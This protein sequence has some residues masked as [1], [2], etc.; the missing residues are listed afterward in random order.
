M[1]KKEKDKKKPVVVVADED[2]GYSD[3]EEDDKTPSQG[4]FQIEIIGARRLAARHKR[5][6]SSFPYCKMIWG[7]EDDDQYVTN[8]IEEELN[9]RWKQKFEIDLR[10]PNLE[11]EEMKFEIWCAKT[12]TLLGEVT[13]PVAGHRDTPLKFAKEH[14]Y[15]LGG[16]KAEPKRQEIVTNQ[17]KK[18]KLDEKAAKGLKFKGDICLKFGCQILEEDEKKQVFAVTASK[19]IQIEDYGS[20][21]IEEMKAESELLAAESNEAAKRALRVAEQ[22]KA[23][24]ADTL[25]KLDS[26]GQKLYNA[27]SDLNQINA[28]LK[29][30]NREL[31]GIHSRTGAMKNSMTKSKW[32]HVDRKNMSAEQRLEFARQKEEERKNKGKKGKK[33]KEEKLTIDEILAQKKAEEDELRK[34]DTMQHLIEN[35]DFDHLSSDTQ[36]NMRETEQTLDAIQGAVKDLHGMAEQMSVTLD[37]QNRLIDELSTTTTQTNAR[38]KKTRM[39]V[40]REFD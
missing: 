7:E 37:E 3:E 9:P 31:R 16:G 20:V 12:K 36:Y 22:T 13:I 18:K 34:K 27:E 32:D 40:R 28:D 15:P 25:G 19:A 17:K 14:W 38:M 30:A 26:Q 8:T 5:T 10:G 39:K 29:E 6:E 24:G 1:G 35:G 33:G 11:V 21:D 23:I 2:E 4:I